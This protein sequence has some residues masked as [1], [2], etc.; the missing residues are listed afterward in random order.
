[1]TAAQQKQQNGSQRETLMPSR[2]LGGFKWAS[3]SESERRRLCRR[4]GG[5]V[6]YSYLYG[7]QMKWLP[8]PS[9]TECGNKT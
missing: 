6:A 9:K 4:F 7:L 1:L 8:F 3:L 5:G 2:L